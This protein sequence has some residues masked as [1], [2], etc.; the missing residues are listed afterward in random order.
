VP[1]QLPPYIGHWPRLA[2]RAD[3][4]TPHALGHPRQFQPSCLIPTAL[5]LKPTRIAPLAS[6]P[7]PRRRPPFLVSLTIVVLYFSL[8]QLTITGPSHWLP[9]SLHRSRGTAL[10]WS[11]SR[12]LH[13]RFP[14]TGTA[15]HQ[16]RATA[17]FSPSVG[18]VTEPLPPHC[19]CCGTSLR[20]PWS[21]RYNRC[22]LPTSLSATAIMPPPNH[23]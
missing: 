3:R 14:S 19:L 13:R 20:I 6:C 22:T 10:P 21:C 12:S 8:L 15:A 5:G 7:Y 9:S 4:S 11:R 1:T 2:A 16:C 17:K 23:R 18:S